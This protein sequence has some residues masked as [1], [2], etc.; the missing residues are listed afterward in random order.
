M[1]GVLGRSFGPTKNDHENNMSRRVAMS[2]AMLIRRRAGGAED[3][4]VEL[5]PADNESL[6]EIE[7]FHCP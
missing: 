6:S 1:F 3:S 5:G 4:A 2:Q 7:L